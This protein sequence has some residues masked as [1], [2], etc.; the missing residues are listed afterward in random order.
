MQLPIWPEFFYTIFIITI[1]FALHIKRTSSAQQISKN[2]ISQAILTLAFICTLIFLLAAFFAPSYLSIYPWDTSNSSNT[3]TTINGLMSPFI[4]IAAAILTFMAFWV[5]YSANQRINDDNKLQ[6]IERQF[7]EMLKIHNDNVKSFHSNA[8]IPT[9]F[10]L[11]HPEKSHWKQ[12]S[13]YGQEY[14]QT[15]LLEFNLAYN[16]VKEKFPE[17]NDIFD[18]AYSIFYYGAEFTHKKG[19]ISE[20][21]LTELQNWRYGFWR[22]NDDYS[23]LAAFGSSIF[24]GH[25]ALLNSY[26]R[27]LFLIVKTIVNIND[28]VLNYKN[29]RQFLRILRAQLTSAEQ[30][31]LFYN[32]KSG[33]GKAWEGMSEK[34][35]IHHFFTDYRMVHNINPNDCIAFSESSLLKELTSVNAEYLYEG[36]SREKDPLFEL[37]H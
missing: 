7:Y 25:L 5:Q 34:G 12:Y 21:L 8:H 24:R 20:D 37:F 2:N 23:K 1:I 11:E 31:L 18:I 13:V 35:A 3:A 16:I 10:S 19:M 29:K 22:G 17:N 32:W 26:Y 9:Y 27:H 4:A 15:S 28:E 6:Q 33:C 36:D 30:V 14:L